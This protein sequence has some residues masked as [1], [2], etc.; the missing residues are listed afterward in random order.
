MKLLDSQLNLARATRSTGNTPRRTAL[1]VGGLLL[2]VGGC[3]AALLLLQYLLSDLQHH[4][5]ATS[6][7]A[8]QSAGRS[9]NF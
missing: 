5:L 3:C 2:I 9:K 8:E 7:Q 4:P 1:L 6:P